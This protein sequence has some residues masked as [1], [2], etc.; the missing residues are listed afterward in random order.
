M[1]GEIKFADVVPEE[2]KDRQGNTTRIAQRGGLIWILSGEVYNLPPGA[3]P[4]VKNGDRVDANS[5]LA[6]SK[7]VTEHG[8]MVRI[9]QE[10]EG[11]KGGR[12]VEI[13]TA[14]VL[15]DQ[16]KV[17]SRNAARSRAILDRDSA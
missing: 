5:I 3:E 9:P 13:I 8:G 12:E 1:A 2:K 7:L 11:N 6:E 4:T 14:S 17:T 15:L 16:A 10:V